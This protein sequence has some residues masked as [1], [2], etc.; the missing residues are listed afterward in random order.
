MWYLFYFITYHKRENASPP[1][2]FAESHVIS[3]A[4]H[5]TGISFRALW[6]GT[7][8]PP[9]GG[10]RPGKGPC[11]RVHSSPSRAGRSEVLCARHLCHPMRAALVPTQVA[12]RSKGRFPGRFASVGH[13]T[14]FLETPARPSP[15]QGPR[16]FS[17]HVPQAASTLSPFSYFP[18][19]CPCSR[20]Q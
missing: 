5:Q 4:L 7:E 3:A 11:P 15:P 10:A 14:V 16:N 19:F 6:L 17:P 18:K 8:A 1:A 2:F 12:F 20:V 13:D 9:Q